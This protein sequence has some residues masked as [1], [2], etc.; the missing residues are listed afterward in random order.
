MVILQLSPLGLSYLFFNPSKVH[1][2]TVSLWVSSG[3]VVDMRAVPR[4]RRRR[5]RRLRRRPWRGLALQPPSWPYMRWHWAVSLPFRRCST[6]PNPASLCTAVCAR[7][8]HCHPTALLT[9]IG[10]DLLRRDAGSRPHPCWPSSQS[11]PGPLRL[12]LLRCVL[13][14]ADS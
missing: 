1:I 4:R 13:P 8:R 10:G 14:P 9:L 12:R 2:V 11:L 3:E 6:D 5:H 7:H